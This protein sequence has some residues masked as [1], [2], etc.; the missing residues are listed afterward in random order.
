[1]PSPTPSS[2]HC[3]GRYPHASFHIHFL[4]FTLTISLFPFLPHPIP[5]YLCGYGDALLRDPT[6]HQVI[7][8]LMIK[9]FK[10]LVSALKKLGTRVVY[11]DFTRIIVHTDKEDLPSAREYIDFVLGAVCS[12]E[13]FSFL[14]ISPKTYWEQVLWLGPDNWGA[15]LLVDDPSPPEVHDVGDQDVDDQDV[16]EDAVPSED[17]AGCDNNMNDAEEEWDEDH[18]GTTQLPGLAAT[19]NNTPSKHKNGTGKHPSAGGLGLGKKGSVTFAKDVLSPMGK[20]SVGGGSSHSNSSSSGKNKRQQDD[21][22]KDEYAFLDTLLSSKKSSSKRSKG[23]RNKHRDDDNNDEFEKDEEDEDDEEEDQDQDEDDDDRNGGN[24]NNGNN[25]D[26]GGQEEESSD[27][28]LQAHW[29][30]AQ[31]LPAAAAEYFYFIV[32]KHQ[33]KHVKIQKILV[34]HIF[35]IIYLFT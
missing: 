21:Q 34:F 7:Y 1:M 4:N 15:I 28:L 19:H 32:G 29:T 3:T 24:Y 14:E 9:L 30:L 33:N 18:G 13:L 25:N 22:S 12:R 8:G 35:L 6:L 31:Y 17:V 11:A 5:R 20:K 26:G 23:D 16:D 2:P 10:R 27:P